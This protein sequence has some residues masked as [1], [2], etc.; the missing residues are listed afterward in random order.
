MAALDLEAENERMIEASTMRLKSLSYSLGVAAESLSI[1]E[2][3][4]LIENCRTAV[5][6]R[7]KA[8]AELEEMTER[9]LEL[10]EK[11]E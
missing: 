6:L 9:W 11:N 1:G 8:E 7:E 4:R 10:E 2:G 3:T 5:S